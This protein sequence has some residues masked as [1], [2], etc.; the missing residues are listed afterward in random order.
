MRAI[1]RGQLEGF[2]APEVLKTVYVEHDI[3]VRGLTGFDRV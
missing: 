3:Q 1:S 2:P